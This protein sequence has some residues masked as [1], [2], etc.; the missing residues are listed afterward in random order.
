MHVVLSSDDNYAKY[1]AIT[2]VSVLCN[3]ADGDNLNFHILDGGITQQ[4]RDKIESMVADRGASIELLPIDQ[5]LF[6]G[7]VLNITEKN[8]VTLATYYRLI[9]PSLLQADRCIYMDCDMICRASLVPVWKAD[10]G[11]CI[12]AAVK[13]IDED[14]QSERLGLTHY[15]NAGFFLMDLKAMREEGTQ[16]QFFRF[17]EEHH[18]RIIM[19]DQDVLNCVLHGR[20]Y[21]LD[22][23][24]NC[25]VT[26]TH[27]CRET[28][29]HDLSRTAN[30]LHYIGRKKPWVKGCRAPGCTAYWD[31]ESILEKRSPFYTFMRKFFMCHCIMIS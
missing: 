23:T 24:W 31:Y 8:H 11:N 9:I 22:M 20:I 3:R 15:F 30:V 5:A 29:F 26:K 10:L 6:S 12:A 2:I 25:Q 27:K 14:K 16:K 19:H 4:N 28:G 18:D 1:L 17:I 13:D 7:K 21:E